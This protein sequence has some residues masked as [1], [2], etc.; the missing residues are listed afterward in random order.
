MKRVKK[1]RKPKEISIDYKNK[2][3]RTKKMKER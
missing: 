3:M 2:E 1:E